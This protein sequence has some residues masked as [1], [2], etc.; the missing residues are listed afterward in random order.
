MLLGTVLG[1][2]ITVLAAAPTTASWDASSC[3]AGVYTIAA[4]ASDLQGHRYPSATLTMTLPAP[5]VTVIWPDLPPGTYVAAASVGGPTSWQS[6]V[7]DVVG[8]GDAPPVV[9]PPDPTDVPPVV[10]T[11]QESPDCTKAVSITDAAGHVYAL[12]GTSTTVDGVPILGQGTMYKYVAKSIYVL[13]TDSNWYQLDA[14]VN[15]SKVG[16][17][18]AC[19][20]APTPVPTP[21]PVTDLSP[22]MLAIQ[23]MG[24]NIL[25]AMVP[26][27]PVAPVVECSAIPF[28]ISKAGTT[29]IAPLASP[30]GQLYICG[31]SF[32]VAATMGVTFNWLNPTLHVNATTGRDI[33][34]PF[35]LVP[36]GVP[37]SITTSS[38]SAVT[39]SVSVR[40]VR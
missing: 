17:E 9:L 11:K 37:V 35:G 28:T 21:V 5:A 7:Q 20:V 19:V 18:P 12:S 29:V 27:P 26:P 3:P 31:G 40:V 38:G 14:S 15:W 6:S 36:A 33:P 8:L 30:S 1:L 25:A 22:V 13:G 24:A 23:K 32:S 2:G 10:T 16:A 34:I 39:G 4:V